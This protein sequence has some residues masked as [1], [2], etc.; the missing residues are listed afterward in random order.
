[1]NA[2]DVRVVLMATPDFGVPTLNALVGAGYQVVGVVC[3][4]DKPVGRGMQVTP[5]PVK[6]AAQALSLPVFQFASLRSAQ[7]TAAFA[8]LQA[9]LIL[10]AAFGQYIPDEIVALPARGCLNLHPSLLPRHRGA[11]PVAAAILAGD[12]VTGVSILFVTSEMDAGD[13]LAQE[14]TAVGA[15]ETT[16]TLTARLADLGAGVFIRTLESW[17]D[18]E[19]VPWPQDA[20]QSTWCDRITKEQGRLDWREPAVM[21][22]RQVRAYDPWPGTFTDWQ[23]TQL[24]VLSAAPRPEWQ[25]AETPGTV[26]RLGRS[27]GVATSGGALELGMLQLANRRP[28]DAVAFA[29]G[30][31]GFVG[32]EL[33]STGPG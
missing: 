9:D 12:A 13:I 31:R 18:G 24:N 2:N 29:N 11:S 15:T 23:G 16:C 28:L 17:L 8:A 5:P 26:V 10:V 21:L 6:R 7:A 33:G 32:A 25:G 22:A 14:P 30:A 20:S 19:I 1:L 3:Q 4:P 27:L